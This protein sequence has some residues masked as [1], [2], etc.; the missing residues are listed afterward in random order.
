MYANLRINLN[1]AIFTKIRQFARI[2]KLNDK[3]RNSSRD[4]SHTIVVDSQVKGQKL[5]QL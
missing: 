1:Y 2:S 3:S 4:V 5:L